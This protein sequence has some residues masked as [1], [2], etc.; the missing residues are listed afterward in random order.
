MGSPITLSGF[1]NIDFGSVLNA[2]MQQERLPVVQLEN[3]QRALQG[4]QGFFS[5]FA[6]KLA[7]LESAAQALYGA[8]SFDGR[9]ATVSDTTAASVGMGSSTPKGSYEILASTLARAQV[10]TTSSSHADTDSTIVA[11]GGVL[12]INGV[13]VTLAGNVTLEGLRDAINSTD[14]VGVVASIVRNGANYQ[15]VLT[16]QETGAAKSF[17]VTNGLTGGSGVAFSATNAQEASDATGTVNGV[18]FSSPTNVISGVIPDGTL[19]VTKQSPLVPIV[20]TITGDRNSIK[21]LVKKFAEAYNEVV[22]FVDDQQRSA[23]EKNASS[24][25]R[26]PLVRNL[27]SQMAQTLNLERSVGGSFT[28]ISQV[29]LSFSRTGRLEFNEAEFESALDRDQAGVEALFR[30]S[31]ATL[32]VF[33][34]FTTTIETYTD[35]GGLIPSAQQRLTDQLLKVGQRITEFERR[36]VARRETLQKEFTAADLAMKQLNA[37]VGQLSSLGGQLSQF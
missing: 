9:S 24:I 36:L 28:A 10:T 20:V 25:G 2:L 18:E 29:G 31:G 17:T 34:A 13:G 27:R 30:G 37:S 22:S 19:T 11:S 23:G 4:Q 21:Q 5:T 33:N 26:D 12:T 6:S 8:D 35:A 16:G 32:G 1:N 14:G 15:L 7:A 3:Q